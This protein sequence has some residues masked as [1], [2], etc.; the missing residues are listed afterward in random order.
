[1]TAGRQAVSATKNWCTPPHIITSVK[2]VFGGTIELDPCSN[3]DSLVDADTEYLLPH[4]D[5]LKEP[6]DAATIFVNPP[7]GSDTTTGTK[8][9]NWFEK[10]STAAHNGSE[11]IALVPVATNTRHWKEHVF[12]VAQAICFL[13]D[14]RFKFYLNGKQDPKGAPMAC[15]LIYYGD[16]WGSFADEFKQYGTV[17]PLIDAEFN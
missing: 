14:S 1:M 9:L 4:T 17:V 11:I 8:I 15:A 7:Y 13:A 2:E 12:P 16:K 3:K 6:W 10:I 5:G